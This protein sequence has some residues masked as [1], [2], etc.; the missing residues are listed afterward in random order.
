MN[1]PIWP[2]PG[3]AAAITAATTPQ[4]LH[5]ALAAL[6]PPGRWDVRCNRWGLVFY[7]AKQTRSV[8]AAAAWEAA[9]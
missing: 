4:E 2:G 9:Q 1:A 8:K 3:P 7:P 5:K 6:L